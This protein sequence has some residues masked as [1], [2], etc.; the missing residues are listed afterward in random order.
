MES[1]KFRI[2]SVDWMFVYFPKPKEM[3][4]WEVIRAQG[5][6]PFYGISALIKGTPESSFT[7]FIIWKYNKNC[8]LATPKTHTRTHAD[9]LIL[10]FQASK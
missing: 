9:T 10:N 6:S 5:W 2:F 4:I 3:E 8:N 7:H 1:K